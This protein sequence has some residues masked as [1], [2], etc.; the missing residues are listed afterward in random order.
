MAALFAH[1]RQHRNTERD[2]IP[3]TSQ[4]HVWIAAAVPGM[5]DNNAPADFFLTN[6]YNEKTVMAAA[7][8]CYI[9]DS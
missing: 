4:E 5:K 8:G 7:T 2:R 6:C 1:S 3:T 9:N